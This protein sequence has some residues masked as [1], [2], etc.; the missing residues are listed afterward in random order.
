[1]TPILAC[2]IQNFRHTSG[3]RKSITWLTI[4][5]ILSS[6]LVLRVRLPLTW[7]CATSNA[8]PQAKFG[9][10]SLTLYFHFNFWALYCSFPARLICLFSNLGAYIPRSWR[11]LTSFFSRVDS[12]GSKLSE[13]LSY[14]KS[15]INNIVASGRITRCAG[16]GNENVFY[17]HME[18]RL[19][20]VVLKSKHV[21]MLLLPMNLRQAE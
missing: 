6:V 17:S 18:E 7:H 20:T 1:M 9:T 13:G 15:F 14:F 12:K 2:T 21:M 16:K 5:K 10:T 19:T 8:S 4:T 3:S 11:G